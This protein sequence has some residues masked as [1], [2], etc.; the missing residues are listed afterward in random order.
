MP[1]LAPEIHV[2][3]NAATTSMA[4]SKGAE[5]ELGAWH[6]A[7]PECLTPE[8]LPLETANARDVALNHPGRWRP[9]KLENGLAYLQ[10]HGAATAK[11]ALDVS[12][13]RTREARIFPSGTQIKSRCAGEQYSR[14]GRS[15]RKGQR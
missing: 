14:H 6:R 3:R 11:A 7:N 8:Y 12:L 13:W 9:C 15:M 1:H 5:G 10:G 2:A 4:T